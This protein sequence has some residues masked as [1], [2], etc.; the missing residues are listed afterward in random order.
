MAAE[1][2][3]DWQTT[4]DAL[5]QLGSVGDDRP[6]G[7]YGLSQG[8]EMGIRLV[9]AEPRITAAVLGLVGSEWLI[10]TAAK[11]TVPVEF[12]LQWDDESNPRDA[13]MRLYDA[14]GSAEKTLHANPGGHFRVPP[15]EIDS[16]IRFFARHLGGPAT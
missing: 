14:L 16:S 7:Y 15:F 9:A 11:I 10:G 8:G 2:I 3:P 1:L 5:Q 13:V 12:L 6:I 4:L